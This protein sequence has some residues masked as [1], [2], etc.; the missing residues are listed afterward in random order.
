MMKFFG[1][2]SVNMEKAFAEI[3]KDGNGAVSFW[4]FMV[5]L[6]WVPVLNWLAGTGRTEHF[7]YFCAANLIGTPCSFSMWSTIDVRY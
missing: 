5:W 3:D 2:E 6:K 7:A 1:Y 4:E